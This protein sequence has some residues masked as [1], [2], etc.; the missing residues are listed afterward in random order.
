MKSMISHHESKTT[1]KIESTCAASAITHAENAT[2]D[3]KITFFNFFLWAHITHL[4]TIHSLFV[5][6]LLFH[7]H[8][9]YRTSISQH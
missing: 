6:R 3:S 2:F 9:D 4:L 8:S 7:T 5:S 1:V